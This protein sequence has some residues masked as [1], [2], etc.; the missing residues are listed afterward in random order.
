M[1]QETGRATTNESKTILANNNVYFTTN[2]SFMALWNGGKVQ[3]N[4]SVT[5]IWADYT[6]H[7]KLWVAKLVSFV[8]FIL[9]VL[10]I[11]RRR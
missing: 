5:K 10:P 9:K 8:S 2:I 4:Q 7:H 3:I 1:L 6:M 11:P